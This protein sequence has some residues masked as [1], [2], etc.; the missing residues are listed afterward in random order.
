MLISLLSH[1]FFDSLSLSLFFFFF[2]SLST[3]YNLIQHKKMHRSNLKCVIENEF[4]H[5]WDREP[6]VEMIFKNDSKLFIKAGGK[7]ADE[8]MFDLAFASAGLEVSAKLGEDDDLEDE[9]EDEMA[10]DKKK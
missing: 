4:Y 1:S 3:F 9:E 8:L 6:T 2:L 10:G 5:Q 7:S